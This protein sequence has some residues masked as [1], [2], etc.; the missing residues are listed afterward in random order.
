MSSRWSRKHITLKRVSFQVELSS[1]QCSQT[2]FSFFPSPFF[3][4]FFFLSILIVLGC[5]VVR[6]WAL[7]AR[8]SVQRWMETLPLCNWSAQ[9]CFFFL[10]L[11][12]DKNT[13]RSKENLMS[14]V[15]INYTPTVWVP[16]G[17]VLFF[18]STMQGTLTLSHVK[19][20][21]LSQCLWRLAGTC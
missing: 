11:Q 20:F 12:Y 2:W 18:N 15:M 10:L 6:S 3:F 19:T 1:F 13:N 17:C 8:M 4:L 21:C 16:T 14:C 5:L 7:K 9:V